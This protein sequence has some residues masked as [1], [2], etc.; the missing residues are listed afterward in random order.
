MDIKK[1]LGEA[2]TKA[3]SKVTSLLLATIAVM[4]IRK[5]IYRI[6]YRKVRPICKN[7]GA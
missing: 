1:I 5:G 7:L 3:L 2:G 4:M 6:Y